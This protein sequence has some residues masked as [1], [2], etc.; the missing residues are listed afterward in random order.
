MKIKKPFVLHLS[1]QVSPLIENHRRFVILEV[2]PYVIY[3]YQVVAREEISFGRVT[4]NRS[5]VVTFQTSRDGGGPAFSKQYFARYDNGD[6]SSDYFEESKSAA[7]NIFDEV[8]AAH[9][10]S[11]VVVLGMAIEVFVVV[12][13]IMSIAVLIVIGVVYKMASAYC[14]PLVCSGED[15]EDDDEDDDDDEEEDGDED[16]EDLEDGKSDVEKQLS[17]VGE[18]EEEKGEEEQSS[19]TNLQV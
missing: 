14:F 6:F 19:Q 8:P 11:P 4:Y 5:P 1:A 12:A 10:E 3:H 18:E 7:R 15:D 17:V 2:V 9:G 13:V 16:E